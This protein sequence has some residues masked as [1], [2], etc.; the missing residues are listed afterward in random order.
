V[1][2]RETGTQKGFSFIEFYD[3]QTAQ[4]AVRNL[5]QHELSGRKLKV[6]FADKDH[7]TVQRQMR[8]AVCHSTVQYIFCNLSENGS[9]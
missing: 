5:D 7:D 1:T 9:H 6:N 4:S 3:W 8:G 2:D